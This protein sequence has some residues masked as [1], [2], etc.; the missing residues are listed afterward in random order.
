[1]IRRES[2]RNA[3][4]SKSLPSATVMEHCIA[5]VESEKS[6]SVG[7][8]S[9]WTQRGSHNATSTQIASTLTLPSC[10]RTRA[11]WRCGGP[12]R[13][14]S[15]ICGRGLAPATGSRQRQRPRCRPRCSTTVAPVR[16]LFN[17][18]RANSTAG[19]Q[20]AQHGHTERYNKSYAK[21]KKRWVPHTVSF[22]FD[23]TVLRQPPPMAQHAPPRALAALYLH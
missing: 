17:R 14:T 3:K 4:A 19:P 21:C 15:N 22:A 16:L 7:C 10:R 11:L 12:S 6:D 9:S 18:R 23:W 5:D 13:Q 8:F 20:K 2:T 1:M